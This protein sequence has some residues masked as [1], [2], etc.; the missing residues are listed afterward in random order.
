MH[1]LSRPSCG[2][3]GERFPPAQLETVLLQSSRNFY[4]DFRN[5]LI[6]MTSNLGAEAVA[7]FFRREEKRD[8]R[9]ISVEESE[10][11]FRLLGQQLA[12][13]QFP[14]ELVGRLDEVRVA[15]WSPYRPLLT[16]GRIRIRIQVLVFKPLAAEDLQRI[17]ALQL[18]KVVRAPLASQRGVGAAFSPDLAAVIVRWTTQERAADDG[19]EALGLGLGSGSELGQGS[20]GAR[21]LRQSIQRMLLRPCARFLLE[22]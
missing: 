22:V 9:A 11:R 4:Q 8:S 18:E 14:A 13:S 7:E 17:C 10:R 19:T 6:L 5:T 2:N 16:V 15:L 20:Y 21:S 1:R 3:S 12:R